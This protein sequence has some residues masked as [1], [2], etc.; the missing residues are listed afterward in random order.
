MDNLIFEKEMS[1]IEENFGKKYSYG[2]TMEIKEAFKNCP[3]DKWGRL[4]KYLR[5][6]ESFRPNIAQFRRA[7]FEVGFSNK[8]SRS[9]DDG[10]NYPARCKFCGHVYAVKWIPGIDKNYVCPDCKISP[11]LPPE[12]EPEYVEEF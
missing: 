10:K 2:I 1:L 6:N 9:Y 7:A 4:C 11:E 8:S 5:D 3:N 12:T